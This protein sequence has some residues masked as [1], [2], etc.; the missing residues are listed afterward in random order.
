MSLLAYRLEKLDSARRIHA[1]TKEWAENIISRAI[2]IGATATEGLPNSSAAFAR[3]LEALDYTAQQLTRCEASVA[4]SENR[5]YWKKRV[6]NELYEN[7]VIVE[8]Y[9]TNERALLRFLLD[10]E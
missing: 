6:F 7:K 9:E 1:E 3:A 8:N 2:K 4:R 5:A 10:R